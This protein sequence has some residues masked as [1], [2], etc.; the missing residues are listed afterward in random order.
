MLELQR[1]IIFGQFVDTGSF[2]HR[3]DPR[4][5]LGATAILV[6][7]AFL[8]SGFA[9]FAALLPLV[10]LIHLVSRV[11]TRFVLQGSRYFLGFLAFI[12]IFEVL[13][14][15]VPSG[16]SGVFWQWNILSVSLAG[17]RLAA[18]LALRVLLLYDVTTMLMLTTPVVDLTD[19]VEIVFGPLQ[20]LRVPVNELALVGVIAVKFVPIFTGEAERLS[21]AQ[22]ARGVPFDEGGP[23]TRARRIGR[24][25]VPIF[26]GGFRRADTLAMAMDTRSYRGGRRRTKLR[27]FHATA[28]DWLALALVLVWILAAWQIPLRL[29][30]P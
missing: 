6:V 29:N 27:T 26:V 24:L 10:L 13:F 18:I 23:I 21:R 12:L 30:W 19:A 1:N 4:V 3:L 14:Y 9:G 28:F 7:G 16:S 8:V 11:P 20:K 17:L 25:L 2:I 15:P 22:T 5:K